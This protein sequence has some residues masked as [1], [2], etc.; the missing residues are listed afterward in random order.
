MRL[1]VGNV[2]FSS[3]EESLKAAFSQFGQVDEVAIITDRETGRS[4]GFA[5]ITMA[6]ASD[7]QTAIEEL[8]GQE[9]DGRSISVNE[10]RP[11][12]DRPRGHGNPRS[13]ARSD[14][15]DRW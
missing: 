12:Q 7:G 13:G 2:A 10:A 14:R 3:T 6:N 11:K 15:N 1:Y 4:R 5:F 8:N 9:V